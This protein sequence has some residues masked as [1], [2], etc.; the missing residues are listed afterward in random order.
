MDAFAKSIS[1]GLQYGVPIRGYVEAF[2]NMKFE[3]A[4]HDRRPGR[5]L[6]RVDH[7]L[8]VPSSRARVHELRRARRA[9]ASSRSPS[10]PSRRCPVST[11]SSSRP[12]RGRRSSPTRRA[13]RRCPS[14]PPASRA[15][16]WRRRSRT[17]RRL[18][19]SVHQADRLPRCACSAA[20]TWCE[21]AAATPARAA[22][23]PAAAA[24]LTGSGDPRRDSTHHRVRHDAVMRCER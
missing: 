4:G 5:P 12:A 23:A 7:G 2:V 13:C 21:P 24:D 22:A 1:Y 15:A 19:A 16:P 10:A 17:T 20:S 9:R 11:R 6:R 3:P 14:W 18:V 8:P